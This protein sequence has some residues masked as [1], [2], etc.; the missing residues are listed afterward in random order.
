MTRAVVAARAVPPSS[1]RRFIKGPPEMSMGGLPVRVP[2]ARGSAEATYQTLRRR[3]IR[4]GFSGEPHL[5]D[6]WPKAPSPPMPESMEKK[7]LRGESQGSS[8]ICATEFRESGHSRAMR[9][10]PLR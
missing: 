8:E 10:L 7:I 9:G 6:H 1:E 2:R 3:S 5:D 4:V